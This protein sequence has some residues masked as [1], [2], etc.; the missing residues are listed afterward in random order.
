MAKFLELK[1]LA[2]PFIHTTD[3]SFAAPGLI[4]NSS[5]VFAMRNTLD[6]RETAGVLSAL[7]HRRQ[8]KL[9]RITRAL[10]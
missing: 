3:S 7:S 4:R 5:T 1:F 9:T 8:R 10:K 2:G 6:C